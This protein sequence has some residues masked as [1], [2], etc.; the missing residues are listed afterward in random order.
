VHEIVIV[1]ADLYVP[2]SSAALLDNGGGLPGLEHVTR[3]ASRSILESGWRPWLARWLSS[4]TGGEATARLPAAGGSQEE[5]S[6]AIT[7][8]SPATIAAWA[9]ATPARGDP[10]T[11]TQ[12]TGTVWLATPVHL[13]AGLT[14]L[15]LDRGGVLRVTEPQRAALARDFKHVFNS[16]GFRLEP[17]ETGEFLLF[18][19]A[20]ALAETR[21]PSRLFGERVAEALPNGAGAGALRR[22][23]T[24]I[25][26]WLHDHPVNAARRTSGDPPITALWLWGGG[27]SSWLAADIE[28]A[29]PGTPGRV[30]V[31]A[32]SADLCFGA[33]PYSAGLWAK[34][35]GSLRPLPAQLDEVFSYPRAQRAVLVMEVGQ[36]LQDMNA[37]SWLEALSQ[38]DRRF[39]TPAVR[40]LRQ[41]K[42]R[43]LV[44]LANDLQWLLAAR[45]RFK[46]WR[47]AYPG[48]TGVQ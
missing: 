48:L 4:S 7:D 34:F 23:G 24:E 18:G 16:S 11:D 37:G 27:T 19:P 15:H 6:C 22:I 28:L 33:D 32:A 40:A 21:E 39:L 38:I 43:R 10:E 12:H 31:P 45:D 35:G 36:M 2:H 9:I 17:L 46:F 26:M 8:I 14:S 1:L 44:V 13:V 3:Y 29:D 25:E 5:E 41:G 47:R 30:A 42:L 20:I